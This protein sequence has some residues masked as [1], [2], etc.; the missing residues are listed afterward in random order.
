MS[1]DYK[2]DIFERA[3]EIAETEF[4]RDFYELSQDDQ[5]E[6]WIRAEHE[7]IDSLVSWADMNS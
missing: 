4:G 3:N 5:S 6:V 7:H 1:T 2:Y